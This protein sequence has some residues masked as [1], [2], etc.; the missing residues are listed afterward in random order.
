MYHPHPAQPQATLKSRIGSSVRNSILLTHEE[1]L[2]FVP[3]A[4]PVPV[5]GTPRLGAELSNASQ[6]PGMPVAIS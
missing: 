3:L 2:T 6:H 4:L 5:N 1:G